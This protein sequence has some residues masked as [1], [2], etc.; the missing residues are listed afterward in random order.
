[1]SQGDLICSRA[2]SRSQIAE[3]LSVSRDSNLYH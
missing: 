1:M 3:L 2:C